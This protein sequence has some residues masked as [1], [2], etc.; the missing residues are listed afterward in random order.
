M[1]QLNGKDVEMGCLDVNKACDCVDHKTLI[2]K[3]ETYETKSNFPLFV[4][5]FFFIS[6]NLEYKLCL[7]QDSMGGYDLNMVKFLTCNLF[8]NN[9]LITC[10]YLDLHW[11][12]Y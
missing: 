4:F 9:R 6:F 10:N 12:V 7:P 11:P 3:I 8:A 1:T 5:F 2:F